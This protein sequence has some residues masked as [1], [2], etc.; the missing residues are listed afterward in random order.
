MGAK[1]KSKGFSLIEVLV[2]LLVLVVVTGA[3]FYAMAYYQRNYGSSRLRA[4]LH[5]DLR[6][7]VELI[8]Q[9]VGEAGLLDFKTQTTSAAITASLSPQ[10][11]ALNSVN[12]IFVGEELVVD[13]ASTQET[14]N[15]TAVNA[16]TS[17]ITAVF[18]LSHAASALVRAY[19]VFPQGVLSSSTSTELRIFGDINGDGTITYVK[20][21][22]DTNAGTLSR[23]MTVVTPGTTASNASDVL[24]R[25]LT[26]NPG[27]TACFQYTSKT[28]GPY[29]F[30][31]SVAIT[32]SART[33]KVDPQTKQY[34][35]MTKSFLNLAPRNVLM[36]LK[37]ALSGSEVRL[38]PT[39]PNIPLT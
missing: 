35:T 7:A 13:T 11:V 34:V 30:V 15:V 28:A 22:C 8:S 18:L 26:A 2:S 6:G 21:T 33:S 38:Q 27:G 25:N 14:V 31:T 39:P 29:T 4:T 16:S 10:S 36:G 3:V 12:S 5:G 1:N 19:G 32:L 20:Y 17:T 9:E 23:S 24:V 37:L